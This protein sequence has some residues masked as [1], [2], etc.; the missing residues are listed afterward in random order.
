MGL[1]APSTGI[2]LRSL[3]PHTSLR[4]VLPLLSAPS[5]CE[6]AGASPLTSLRS[7]LPLLSAPSTG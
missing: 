1:S 2:S 6:A 4:S 3:P 7:V 5:G